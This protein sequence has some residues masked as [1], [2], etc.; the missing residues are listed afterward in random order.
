[1]PFAPVAS[2]SSATV[3]GTAATYSA[4]GLD[5]EIIELNELPA[6]EVKIT[7]ITTGLDDSFLKQALLQ[8]VTTYYDNRSDFVTG[9]IVQ[10]IKTSTRNLLSS[11][12]TVF[13]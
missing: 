6:K 5:N 12:K 10:E 11:Y 3:D 7:Y 4:K 13:I 8:M 1:L 2:I 9:T